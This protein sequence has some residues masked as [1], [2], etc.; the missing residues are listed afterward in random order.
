MGHV[1]KMNLA[2]CF[3]IAIIVGVELTCVVSE[4]KAKWRRLGFAAM[5]PRLR[6]VC[7]NER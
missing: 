5:E 4:R 2:R 1:L 6:A 3:V 7:A